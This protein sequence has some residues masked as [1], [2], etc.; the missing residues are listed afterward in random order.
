[1]KGQAVLLLSI[2]KIFFVDDNTKMFVFFVALGAERATILLHLFGAKPASKP[3]QRKVGAY[4]IM[5]MVHSVEK[6][7]FFACGMQTRL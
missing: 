2:Q 4:L 1:M 7:V 6:T 5:S 3:K